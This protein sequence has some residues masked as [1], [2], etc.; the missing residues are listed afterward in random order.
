MLEDFAED[1]P[2]TLVVV[3]HDRVFLDRVVEDVLMLDEGRAK[4]VLGG[5]AGWIAKRAQTGLRSGAGAAGSGVGASG[6][7]KMTALVSTSAPAS[8]ITPALGTLDTKV[9]IPPVLSPAVTAA[10]KPRRSPSTLRNLIKEADRELGR[11]TKRVDALTAELESV[12]PTDYTALARIGEQMGEAHADI[13]RWEETW[14][15]LAEES[16]GE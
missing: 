5:Y 4:P 2:G 13:A 15:E 10:V 3:S 6:G 12:A 16:H 8:P 14:L 7:A 9:H 11:A 1:W